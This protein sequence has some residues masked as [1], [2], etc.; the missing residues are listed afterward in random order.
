MVIASSAYDLILKHAVGSVVLGVEDFRMQEDS[1]EISAMRNI[2]AGLLLLFKAKLVQLGDGDVLIWID[3]KRTRTVN[4]DRIKELFKQ[5]K[6]S[7]EW[8]KL[9][10]IRKY[11]NDIEHLYDT[12]RLKRDSVRQYILNSF[13]IVCSFMRDH[14]SKD[15]QDL[16][17]PEPWHYWMEEKSIFE[18]QQRECSALR[19]KFDWP[20]RTSAMHVR[21]ACCP[22]CS[23]ILLK[24]LP[25]KGIHSDH[26]DF[27]C[28]VCG[29]DMDFE[30]LVIAACEQ[31]EDREFYDSKYSDSSRFGE[32]IDC[33]NNTYD[34]LEGECAIC[35][36]GPFVCIRC[37]N[38]IS[39]DEMAWDNGRYCGYCAH[40]MAKDD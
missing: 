23:S 21:N 33:A 2:Y 4:Y 15:P 6:I 29:H 22:E 11:R 14:L 38:I 16:F 17:D 19:D 34:A 40:Q 1:R 9:V 10:E 24:P 39:T 8:S 28:S 30:S 26:P 31:V 18:Q 25:S 32:C 5:H 36:A 13:S 7:V 35:G 27:R 3:E 37:G 20:T 12:R